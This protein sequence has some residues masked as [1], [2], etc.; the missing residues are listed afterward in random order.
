MDDIG[1]QSPVWRFLGG[2]DARDVA[3]AFHEA[4]DN[5]RYKIPC[6]EFD[7]LEKVEDRGEEEENRECDGCGFRRVVVVEME[8]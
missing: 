5:D 8:S 2:F 1:S 7:E 4:A 3:Y 6:S